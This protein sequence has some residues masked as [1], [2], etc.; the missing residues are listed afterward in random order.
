MTESFAGL[1]VLGAA[2]T[3]FTIG[4]VVIRRMSRIDF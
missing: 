2:L 1:V 3:L 4:F